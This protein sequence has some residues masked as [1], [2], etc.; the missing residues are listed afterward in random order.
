MGR[1]PQYGAAQAAFVAQVRDAVK[2]NAKSFFA[3]NNWRDVTPKK[4]RFDSS[5]IYPNSASTCLV[6]DFYIKSIS[7]W[8]P[9]LLIP[10]HTHTCPNCKDSQSVS[11]DSARWINAPK[12]L[13]GKDCHRYLDTMLYPCKRCGR[14]FAGYN[15]ESMQLDAEVYFGHFN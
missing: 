11:V 12:I 3:S 1:S 14:H 7:V 10:A 2:T 6:D 5:L 13:H 15:K 8:V 4:G 9:H